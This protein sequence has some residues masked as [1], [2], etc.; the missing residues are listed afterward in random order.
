M[1]SV[2]IPLMSAAGLHLRIKL[3]RSRKP[4][5]RQQAQ[6]ALNEAQPG[7]ARLGILCTVGL[8]LRLFGLP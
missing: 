4:L 5:S 8:S 3:F 1:G 7:H 2:G 6:P